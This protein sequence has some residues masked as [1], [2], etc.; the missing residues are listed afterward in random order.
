MSY[1]QTRQHLLARTLRRLMADSVHGRRRTRRYL[2]L[3]AAQLHR[4]SARHAIA[5]MALRRVS[6]CAWCELFVSS[7]RLLLI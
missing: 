2:H 6:H 5:H 3:R 7:K 1:L 4:R